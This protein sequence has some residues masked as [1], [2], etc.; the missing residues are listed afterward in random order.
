MPRVPA[1]AADL[2]SGVEQLHSHAYRNEAAL[3]AGAVLVVGSGQSGVQIAEELAE[4]GRR[5]YLSVGTCGRAPRRYRGSDLFHWLASLATRGAQ[6]GVGMPTVDRLPTPRAKFAANPQLSGHGGGHD[7]NLREFAA[8]GMTLLGRIERVNGRR[9]V[10]A[11]DLFANLARADAFFDERFRSLID[12]YIERAGIDAPPDDRVPVTFD[13]PELADLSLDDAGITSVIW[14]SG[15][16]MDYGWLDAP[17]LDEDGYP[18]NVRGVSD[19]PG[20]YFLGLLWQHTQVSA[21]LVGPT[22]DAM[23]L[24][25]HMDLPPVDV[26]MPVLA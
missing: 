8:R 5:V 4:A 11:G 14:A 17:I 20:L 2:P 1:I 23:H 25:A 7:I 24:A 13:P 26:P 21:T 15:Y 9:L 12:T 19:V 10:L 22:I 3:P 6:Y 16:R 18:R